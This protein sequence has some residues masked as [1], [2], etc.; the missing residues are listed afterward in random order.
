MIKALNKWKRIILGVSM[1]SG[2]FAQNAGNHNPYFEVSNL[3]IGGSSMMLGG[4][5]FVMLPGASS[6]STPIKT[7]ITL[8]Y[9]DN[10][11][12]P[13]QD[14]TVLSWSSGSGIIA[15]YD[16]SSILTMPKTWSNSDQSQVLGKVLELEAGSDA[17][18]GNKATLEIKHTGIDAGPPV[19]K[20]FTVIQVEMDESELA[21]DWIGV[22]NM[23]YAFKLNEERNLT[24]T[25]NPS[26]LPSGAAVQFFT[27]NS[28]QRGGTSIVGNDTFSQSGVIKVKA[29]SLSDAYQGGQIRVFARL[30][31]TSGPTLYAT[32]GFG[33]TALPTNWSEYDL[34]ASQSAIEYYTTLIGDWDSDTGNDNDLSEVLLREVVGPAVKSSSFTGDGTIAVGS[35][36]G[37]SM[38]ATKLLQDRFSYEISSIDTSGT[39]ESRRNQR[40]E[41]MDKRSSANPQWIEFYSTDIVWSIDQGAVLF[42]RSSGYHNIEL[43]W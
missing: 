43:Q 9:R 17:S 5:N 27:S 21:R 28:D 29:D 19:S 15:V 39:G 2:L 20:E 22:G 12:I 10:T 14:S 35:L 30:G 26:P 42:K 13:T 40:Y 1:A 38:I 18:G 37:Q 4:T 41:I 16:A 8:H 33:V 25:I 34:G 23:P 6:T 24:V 3:M 7:P 36:G 32:P 31:D 11:N